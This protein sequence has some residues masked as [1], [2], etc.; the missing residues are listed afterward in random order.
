MGRV[1][2]TTILNG[3]SVAEILCC[4]IAIRACLESILFLMIND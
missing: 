4:L 2:Q 1:D 3:D